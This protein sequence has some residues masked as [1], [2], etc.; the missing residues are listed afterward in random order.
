MP[1]KGAAKIFTKKPPFKFE[2]PHSRPDYNKK[3]KNNK[4]NGALF[5]RFITLI[6]GFG[7]IIL[8]GFV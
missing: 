8:G 1:K 4:N 5:I 7:H 2:D 6:N 3:D